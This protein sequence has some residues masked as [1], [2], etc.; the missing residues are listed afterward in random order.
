MCGSLIK[1]TFTMIVITIIIVL[2]FAFL[3]HI[4]GVN[5]QVHSNEIYNEMTI[6]HNNLMND[7]HMSVYTV[8][9]N[10]DK[11]SNKEVT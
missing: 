4:M 6:N 3:A 11:M 2:P 1:E 10:V 9:S 7:I 8:K 5:Y